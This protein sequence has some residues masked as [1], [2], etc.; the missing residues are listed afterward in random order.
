VLVFINGKL[1]PEKDAVISVF[2]RG[3]LLGDG[4]FETIRIFNGE[5]FRWQLHWKRLQHGAS[6]LKIQCPFGPEKLQAAARVLV[7]KNRLPDSLLRLTLTRGVGVRGYSPK[8][9]KR[10]TLVMSLHPAPPVDAGNRPKWNLMTSSV[11][12]PAN[13]PIAQFKSC[14][15]L[16]Q[17]LARAEADTKRAD[18]ALLLNTNGDVIEGAASNLFWIDQGVVFT[19]PLVAGI[20]PGVTRTV[21][22]EL[23]R[24]L[25]IPAGEKNIRP[26]QLTTAG[27][28]FVSLSSYGVVEAT[29][30]DGKKL[31]RSPLTPQIADAY[32]QTLVAESVADRACRRRSVPQIEH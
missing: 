16:P 15:K 26:H 31:K 32:E 19:P 20:L 21:V 28:V 22:L 3:F 29:S 12:L 23:C 30:L 27:G 18:E 25:R 8:G 6:F 2:D 17:I 10:P 13:E 5:P 14:N 9:A 11:R 1:V 4:L 24:R 7:K